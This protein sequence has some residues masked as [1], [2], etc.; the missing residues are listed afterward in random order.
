MQLAEPHRIK[1]DLVAELDL[2][3]DVVIALRLG[4]AAGAWQLVEKA[5]AHYAFP[6]NGLLIVRRIARC[7]GRRQAAQV[8]G[9]APAAQ[10]GA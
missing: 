9:T 2:G 1:P 3:E 10:S 7:G 6:P 8:G 4:K 5:E